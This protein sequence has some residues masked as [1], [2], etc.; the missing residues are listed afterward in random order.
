MSKAHRINGNVIKHFKIIPYDE[1]AEIL[2]EDGEAFL[3]SA[4][5][6]PLK[7]ATIWKAARRLSEIVGKKVRYDR[8]LLKIGSLEG[9]IT[10]EGYS[11]SL[12]ES[13][14]EPSES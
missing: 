4:P 13:P 12:E 1:L 7:R 3:E 5:D 2:K 6:A 14:S 8:S 11:F 10:L 9:T